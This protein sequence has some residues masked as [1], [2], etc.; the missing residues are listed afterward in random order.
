[1]GPPPLYQLRETR[2]GGTT[3]GGPGG[4]TC[5]GA[6]GILFHPR[7]R[8]HAHRN[9]S[10]RDPLSPFSP[11]KRDSSKISFRGIRDLTPRIDAQERSGRSL[12]KWSIFA[13]CRKRLRLWVDA[14]CDE[15]FFSPQAGCTNLAL[16]TATARWLNLDRSAQTPMSDRS[17]VCFVQQLERNVSVSL[18]IGSDATETNALTINT[19]VRIISLG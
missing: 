7:G 2:P 4:T 19:D 10:R 5:P 3:S 12:R 8:V 1:V 16:A 13:G 9:R 11:Q 17:Q 6:P 15:Q 14:A 18:G